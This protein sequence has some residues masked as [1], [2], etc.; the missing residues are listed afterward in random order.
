MSK[1]LSAV[2]VED[3]LECGILMHI[4]EEFTLRIGSV[5]K[6]EIGDA[7]SSVVIRNVFISSFVL[8]HFF[9]KLNYYINYTLLHEN[10]FSSFNNFSQKFSTIITNHIL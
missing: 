8:F 6:S 9:F 4:G 3:F 7:T 2:V 1:L 5:C 10:A